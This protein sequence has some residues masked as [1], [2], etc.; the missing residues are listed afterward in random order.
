MVEESR[1]TRHYFSKAKQT[2]PFATA[3]VTPER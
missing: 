2:L 1:V 3:I